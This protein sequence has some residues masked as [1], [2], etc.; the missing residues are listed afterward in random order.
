[1]ISTFTID[2]LPP[3]LNEIIGQARTHWSKGA[4]QKKEWTN[5]VVIQLKGQDVPAFSPPIWLIFT[6]Y[7]PTFGNDPDNV[8]AA[9]KF[10]LDGMVES[11]V[12]PNDNLMNIYSPYIHF[13]ERGTKKVEVTIVD[14]WAELW[15]VLGQRKVC[16]NRVN[17]PKGKINATTAKYTD[18]RSIKTCW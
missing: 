14:D 5:D 10:I 15:G 2:P 3:T 4:S 8:S 13:Y 17:K 6:W 7:I 1:M 9:A 16:H 11:G 12:I 18:N